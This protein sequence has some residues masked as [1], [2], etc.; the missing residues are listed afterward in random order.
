MLSSRG[1]E[2]GS[3]GRVGEQRMKRMGNTVESGRGGMGKSLEGI[4]I[5][6]NE[7]FY[8]L[9]I[10]NAICLPV[11]VVKYIGPLTF[12]PSSIVYAV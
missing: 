6:V 4:E 9:G 12:V 3:W 7:V 5:T 8:S 10:E 2:R 1:L 11:F